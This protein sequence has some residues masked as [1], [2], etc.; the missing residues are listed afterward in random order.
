[1]LGST[2]THPL[3]TNTDAIIAKLENSAKMVISGRYNNNSQ[4][5]YNLLEEVYPELRP[6]VHGFNL[7]LRNQALRE[8]EVNIF[9]VPYKSFDSSKK[10][11]LVLPMTGDMVEDVVACY[12]KEDLVRHYL[13][14]DMPKIQT[15]GSLVGVEDLEDDMK[16]GIENARRIVS[17][18]MDTRKQA[19]EAISTNAD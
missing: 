2:I 19:L 13:K 5:V 18:F 7:A 9:P 8:A 15:Y 14:G 10:H 16:G 1:M 17:Y 11:D 12:S 6:L 4:L 3:I